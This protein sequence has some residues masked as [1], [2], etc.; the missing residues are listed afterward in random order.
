MWIIGHPKGDPYWSLTNL[1]SFSKDL[2]SLTSSMDLEEY[3]YLNP[4]HSKDTTDPLY[5]N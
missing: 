5:S 2:E 3:P 1:K 4:I